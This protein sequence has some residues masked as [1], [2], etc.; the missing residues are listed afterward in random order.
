MKNTIL[1]KLTG[2]LLSLS[3]LLA[4]AYVIPEQARAEDGYVSILHKV[5]TARANSPIN[6]N[7]SLSRKSDINF[8]ISTNERTGVTISVKEPEHGTPISSISLAV[9]NPDWKYLRDRGIY[10]NT[11]K[12]NLEGGEYIL[13]LRFENDVNFDMSMNQKSL[14]ATLNKK[15]T[16]ITAGFTDTLKVN[17]G[18]I[19]SCSSA[20]KSIATVNNSGKITAKKN[21]STTVK[22][23]LT[24]GKTLSCKVTVVSNRFKAKK[25]SVDSA[26]YDTCSMKAY[27]ASFDKKGNLVVKFVIVNNSYGKIKN[28]PKFKITVKD[29]KGKV[30]A[31]YSKN[32]YNQTIDG[33]NSKSC[34]V[35]IPKTS[36]KQS[37]KK[38][39]LRKCSISITG[40]LANASM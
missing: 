3:L 17:G 25:I 34:S 8:V 23:K 26:E 9:T 20:N 6:Y 12:S 31:T 38:T 16:T 27:D 7:F 33:Y 5:S 40:Q 37:S 30:I 28:I 1:K 22:V 11:V 36:L 19:K 24:N 4:S 2:L 18:K 13:E 14:E 35:T 32:P 21:G 15:S 29:S 10:Q 39:D